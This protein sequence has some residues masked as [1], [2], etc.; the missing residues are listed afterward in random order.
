MTS[1]TDRSRAVQHMALVG[2]AVVAVLS[3]GLICLF[4]AF[5]VVFGV[6]TGYSAPDTAA[7]WAAAIAEAIGVLSFGITV[8]TIGL[9]L[10]ATVSVTL[11]RTR[12]RT[13]RNGAA[14]CAALFAATL[15]FAVIGGSAQLRDIAARAEA[16]AVEVGPIPVPWADPTPETLTYAQAHSEVSKMVRLSLDAAVG[17]VVAADGRPVDAG[18]IIPEMSACGEARTKLSVTLSVRTEDNAR[19]LQRILAAWTAAGY[20]TDRAMQSDIRYSDSLPVESLTIRDSSTI[21]GLIRLQILSQ[22]LVAGHQ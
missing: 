19:S 15:L 8:S 3:V 20:A 16:A 13:G 9:I 10:A 11:A 7:G 12:H 2:G 6:S 5:V 22:C 17:A 4:V 21:D 1:G 18:V 14:L